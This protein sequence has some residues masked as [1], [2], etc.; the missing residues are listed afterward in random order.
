MYI[1]IY[2]HKRK[3]E[4]ERERCMYRDIAG[5]DLQVD[6]RGGPDRS[7]LKADYHY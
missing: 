5:A 7:L 2:I 3:R 4:K 6:A 1:Y